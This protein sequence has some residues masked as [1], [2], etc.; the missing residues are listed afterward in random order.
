MKILIT[1]GSGG[2]GKS[3]A[4]QLGIY[5]DVVTPSRDELDLSNFE[6]INNTDL[7]SYDVIVNCAGSN[8]GAYQGWLNNTWNNQENQVD[9]N[10]TGALLLAKQ[11]VKQRTDG[12]FVFITSYNIE[13]PMALNIFYTASKAALRYS[14][15]TLRKDV[16]GIV[17]TEICPG[18]IYTNML[19]QN[20]QGT[21][22]AEEI[23]RIYQQTPSLDP[24]S[25]AAAIETA[26]KYKLIQIT[27]VPNDQTSI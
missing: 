6:Q 4:R 13:D 7:S 25:V 20:Y 23:D 22:T 21:K 11:Y 3:V 18:K 8:P 24:N 26:I 27:L 9:V 5:H 17:F 2:V 19:N 14:M 16:P 12:Q 15:Q 10:F 1:G